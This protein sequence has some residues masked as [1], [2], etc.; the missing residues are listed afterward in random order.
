MRAGEL[1]EVFEGF[2]GEVEDK[3]SSS[4]SVLFYANSVRGCIYDFVS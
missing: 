1:L 4:I 2:V 3:C